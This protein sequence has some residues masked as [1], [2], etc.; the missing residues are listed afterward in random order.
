[1]KP[2]IFLLPIKDTSTKPNVDEKIV[3]FLQIIQKEKNKKFLTLYC[4]RN[5]IESMGRELK[6]LGYQVH[7]KK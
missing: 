6:K 1:M 3:L 7:I 4:E 5:V 2:L